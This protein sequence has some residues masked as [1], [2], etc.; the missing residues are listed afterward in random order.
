MPD[1]AGGSL[2]GR[3]RLPRRAAAPAD[4]AAAQKRRLRR[5]LALVAFRAPPRLSDRSSSRLASRRR[6]VLAGSN[7]TPPEWR[8]VRPERPR[9]PYKRRDTAGGFRVGGTHGIAPARHP[10]RRFAK[11][12]PIW[13]HPPRRCETRLDG[14]TA[15]PN[16]PTVEIVA[17]IQSVGMSVAR[18]AGRSRPRPG[19]AGDCCRAE[20]AQRRKRAPPKAR[21]CQGRAAPDLSGAARG[22]GT[23]P[24]PARRPDPYCSNDRWPAVRRSLRPVE[25]GPALHTA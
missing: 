25:P 14:P 24:K 17:S 6:R 9:R 15:T 10:A 20:G 19:R 3:S 18:M 13:L 22:V 2:P 7:S 16:R 11:S 8:T 12:G 4:Q 21:R 5:R 1:A 23:P